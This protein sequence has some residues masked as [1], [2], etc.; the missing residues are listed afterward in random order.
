MT[1]QDEVKRL[2]RRSFVKTTAL[3][4]LA[5]SAGSSA[6]ASLYGCDPEA[7][8]PGASTSSV[9]EKIVWGHCAVNCGSTCALQF[10]VRDDEIVYTESD[11]LGSAEFGDPQL[12]A[13]LRGR[14]IRRWL[15][16]PDRLKY[17]M[18]RVAG[19]R[20]GEG[21]YEQISWE[22]ALDTIAGEMKRIR[23]TYGNEAMTI[24]YASGITSGNVNTSA[25]DRLM[26]LTG[27]YLNYYGSYSSAHIAAAS[28]YTYGGGNYGSTFTTLQNG[29]LVVLFGNSP[30]DTRMGGVGHTYDFSV[31]R[32]T[33]NLRVILIDYRLSETATAQNCEWI[34]IRPG[35]DGALVAGIAHVLIT[36]NLVDEDF[37]AKYCVGYDEDS[38]PE[39]AVPNSSYKSYILGMGK[40]ATAKTP[41][42]AAKITQ[43]PEKRIIDLAHE[44]AES[45]P[46]YICQGY[47]SQRHSNGEITARSIMVL[48]Q[49]LGQIGRDG[50]NDGRREGNSA[51]SLGSLPAGDNPVKTRLPTFLWTE[52]IKNGEKLTSLNAGVQGAEKLSSSIKFIWNYAGNTLTNQHSDINATHEI[53]RDDSLCEFIVTSELFMT[54]S[55]KYS[56][57]ILPDLT[58]QEQLSLS[59][60]GYADDAEALIF[61]Q[62]VYAPKFERRGIYQ[63]CSDLAERLGVSEAFTEGKSREDWTRELYEAA[64]EKDPDLPTWEDG[65]ALG[66]YKRKPKVIV[67]LKAFIDDPEAKPL[68]TESGKIQIYSEKL[69]EFAR[70][71]ELEPD[72]LV[73]PIPEYD[74]GFESYLNLTEEYPLI[75]TGFHYKGHT[76]SSYA[77]NKVLEQAA[78]HQLWINPIDAEPR[79][80]K[81]GDQLRVFN[82]RGEIRIEA[83]V[84]PRIIP[85]AVALPQGRWHNADMAGDKVD[86]GGCI[87]TLTTLRPSPLAKANPQHTN[88]GQVEKVNGA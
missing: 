52:A 57:I 32:E 20:R 48:P 5:A 39:S 6:L 19:T 59:K 84:T 16:D 11:N 35:T 71:W 4:T 36:E 42:W 1:G 79:G 68:P 9:D 46:V 27:G 86:F 14:S 64:R 41:A 62:P 31:M 81:T 43:I 23:E 73:S 61:G 82:A 60:D 56:D 67:S 2:S 7:E 53:L 78:R 63:V 3:A 74:P 45:D 87:N 83:K 66:V 77:N 37:L 34:P 47:G 8:T 54:D 18:R 44:M 12:R 75:V 51:I 69:A 15:S 70:T 10:H 30:S 49:L 55:A 76:H 29:Q 40:D 85:G 28:T 58:M 88:I 38:L 50:T 22:E 25:V 13:C 80:I 72:E 65:L 26:N 21:Q 24:H 33:K 17:P